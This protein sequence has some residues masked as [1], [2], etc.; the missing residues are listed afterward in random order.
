MAWGCRGRECTDVRGAAASH[1]HCASDRL[2]FRPHWPAGRNTP[3]LTCSGFP[4][5]PLLVQGP[6]LS[7]SKL[8]NIDTCVGRWTS[9]SL[10]PPR[11]NRLRVKKY[12]PCSTVWLC[13]LFIRFDDPCFFLAFFNLPYE[14]RVLSA[15]TLWRL[16]IL[17]LGYCHNCSRCPSPDC[18]VFVCLF[19]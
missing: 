10:P 3:D 4:Q 13:P 19:F 8:W 17:G 7:L 6:L 14:R 18:S 11:E 16:Q 9:S 2:H 15:W 1:C 12:I 5:A